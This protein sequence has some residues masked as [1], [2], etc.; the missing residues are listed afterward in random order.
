MASNARQPSPTG[1]V[2]SQA[3][4]SRT[5]NSNNP[6]EQL[7]YIAARLERLGSENTKDEKVEYFHGDRSKLRFFL[8]QVKTVFAIN[9]GKY[10][11]AHK[12]V[13]FAAMHLRGP[14]FAW[15][16]P[17]LTDWL[18]SETKETDT[19]ATFG[20]FAH[21]EVRLQQVFGSA[22]DEERTAA[23]L[24]RQLKQKASTAQYYAEFQQLAS[25]LDWNDNALGSAFYEGLKD[26]VK[27]NMEDPPD[28]YQA[29]V[30]KSIRVDNRLFERRMEKR[31]GGWHGRSSGHGTYHHDPMDLSLMNQGPPSRGN[32]RFRGRGRKPLTDNERERRKNENLCYTC[33]KSGHRARECDSKPQGLHMM[34]DN[35]AT[36]GISAKKADTDMKTRMVG[37]NQGSETQETKDKGEGTTAQKEPGK[38]QE[39]LYSGR[40]AADNRSSKEKPLAIRLKD[41]DHAILSWTACYNDHCLIHLSEKEG[42]NW[43]PQKK[44]RRQWKGPVQAESDSEASATSWILMLD[45]GKNTTQEDCDWDEESVNE[46][47]DDEQAQCNF[48]LLRPVKGRLHIITNRWEYAWCNMGTCSHEAQHTHPV[49]NPKARAKEYVRRLTIKPCDGERCGGSSL[50]HAHRWDSDEVIE[51]GIPT[52]QQENIWKQYL[53]SIKE[54]HPV[55][56]YYLQNMDDG[57]DSEEEDSGETIKIETTIDER[58]TDD[59]PST[60]FDCQDTECSHYYE[61]H[62]HKYNIDPRMPKLPLHKRDHRLMRL[63]GMDCTYPLTCEWKLTKHLHLPVQDGKVVTDLHEWLDSNW[64]NLSKN[65]KGLAARN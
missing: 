14:A 8:T 40:I 21:F 47:T 36:A 13:L 53:H 33:G 18:E 60:T 62:G 11:N 43:Y 48:V 29:L 37:K 64:A 20:S 55:P 59:Y 12:Q 19:I 27:D 49:F 39:G 9:S 35:G 10:P 3:G 30:E 41:Q 54:T 6:A 15:F 34:N 4:N 25:K 56:P 58:D 65:D 26:I 61:E 7:N 17:T 2:R 38:V 50:I 42:A 22:L 46:A 45:D 52:Q 23:R 32:N 44:K 28:T 51:L 1:S 63:S 57:M 31:G 24:I 16:E 5:S